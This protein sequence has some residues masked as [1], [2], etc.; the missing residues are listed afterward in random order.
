MAR[1][2][3]VDSDAIALATSASI[4]DDAEQKHAWSLTHDHRAAW[5]VLAGVLAQPQIVVG[6][7][8]IAGYGQI[9]ACTAVGIHN[10]HQAGLLQCIRFGQAKAHSAPASDI[11]NLVGFRSKRVKRDLCI[12]IIVLVELLPVLSNNIYVS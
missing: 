7:H 9:I 4:A 6:A 5:I 2:A 1:D 3:S 10:G 11:D 12:L 8:L